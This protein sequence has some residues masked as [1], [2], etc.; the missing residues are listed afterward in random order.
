MKKFFISISVFVLALCFLL[1]CDSQGTYE[2]GH[3]AGYASG[4]SDAECVHEDDYIEG[5]VEGINRAQ[6]YIKSHLEDD[7][8]HISFEIK[9]EYG[10]DPE[11]AL[12][13]LT[14]YIDDPEAISE[15]DL[16]NAIYAIRRCYLGMYEIIHC[17]DDY[18]I[19]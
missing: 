17:V 16:H 12:S 19:D 11:D 9:K 7:M 6:N 8:N 18:W 13:I 14:N 2:D 4:Y 1:A 5:Y 10:I 15:Q 3:A